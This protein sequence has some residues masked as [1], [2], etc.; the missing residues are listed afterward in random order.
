[1]I[2]SLNGSSFRTKGAVACI[3]C[4][5]LSIFKRNEKTIASCNG[6]AVAHEMHQVNVA[7]V[8]CVNSVEANT[9]RKWLNFTRKVY[10]RECSA[11]SRMSSTPQTETS[12]SKLDRRHLS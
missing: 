2:F 12:I 7:H 10:V 11:T 6:S 1:M 4:V 5:E 8:N 3:Q 9:K